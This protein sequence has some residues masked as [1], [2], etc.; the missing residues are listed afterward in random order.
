MD[1]SYP[2]KHRARGLIPG[3]SA[4]FYFRKIAEKRRGCRAAIK[5]AAA[6]LHVTVK[7]I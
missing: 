2:D 1:G 4:A 6:L 3:L 7:R 5:I